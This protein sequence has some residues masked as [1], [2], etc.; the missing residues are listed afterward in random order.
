[1]QAGKNNRTPARAAAAIIA[2]ATFAVA[3]R[4]TAQEG[5][6]DTIY[7]AGTTFTQAADREWAYVIWDNTTPGP[8][9][10]Q[11]F[12][13]YAKAGNAPSPG[14]Y[15]RKSVLGVQTDPAV[16]KVLL[17]RA[18]NIGDNPNELDHRL[19]NLFQHLMPPS[20]IPVEQKLAIVIQGSLGDPDNYESLLLLAR[21]HPGV[22]M[23]LG[24]AC[25]ELIS[26]NGPTTF[27]IRQFDL[28][29]NQDIAVVGRVTVTAKSPLVLPAPGA[30]VPVPETDNKG[31]AKTHSAKGNL[32]VKLR[33]A[34]PHELRRLSIM[35]YGFNVY[36]YSR[37]A[38]EAK[39]YHATPPSV[40][41]LKADGTSGLAV[42]INE[43]PIITDNDFDPANPANPTAN[44]NDVANFNQALGGD[45]TTWFVADDNGGNR[46]GGVKFQNGD[47]FYYFVTA[48]DI[49]GR[50]GLVSPGRLVTLCDRLPPPAPEGVE[51]ENDYAFDAVSGTSSQRLKVLWRPYDGTNDTV[52]G[53]HVYR[54][55]NAADVQ[56]PAVRATNAPAS[57]LIPL[58]SGQTTQG[59]V[60]NG[61]NAPQM[62]LHSGLAFWYTVRAVDNSACGGNVSPDSAP[63]F[64]VLRDRVG[65]AAPTGRLL[66]Q[67]VRPFVEFVTA[68][69]LTWQDPDP[70][71]AAYQI[72]CTRDGLGGEEIQWAEFFWSLLGHGGAGQPVTSNYI[73][74]VFFPPAYSPGEFVNVPLLI[75]RSN[76]TSADLM[77]YCRAGAKNGK[78]SN[79][80]PFGPAPLPAPDQFLGVLFHS[81]IQT[82]RTESCDGHTP[83][84]PGTNKITGIEICANVTAGAKEY[85]IYRRVDNGPLTLIKQGK[86]EGSPV[87]HTNLDLPGSSGTI[88][89]YV[90]FLDEHGNASPVTQIGDCTPV[91]GLGKLPKPLLAEVEA[92]GTKAAPR[93]ILRWFCPPAGIDRFRV[94]IAQDF[95]EPPDVFGPDL[96]PNIFANQTPPTSEE[97][98][99][100]DGV[101]TNKTFKGYLT[102]PIGPAFGDGASFEVDV[103][104]VTVGKRYTVFVRAVDKA[105]NLSDP[106]NGEQFKWSVHKKPALE[107]PW[108]ARDLPEVSGFNSNIAAMVMHTNSF[109]GLGVRIGHHIFK[110][111][112]DYHYR[113]LPTLTDPVEYL[114]DGPKNEPLLP[115]AMYRY[116]VANVFFPQVSGDV[117]QV[118]PLMER[119]AFREVTN[120]DKPFV[121]IFD[122]FIGM[123]PE[124]G[125]IAVEL[126]FYLIGIH[127]LDTQPV[128]RGAAYRYLLVRFDP[129]T[130]EIVQVIPTN[131]VHVP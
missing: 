14:L 65:P 91:G 93:M 38:A 102:L 99:T 79:L 83:V 23:C 80:A 21:L 11:H 8:A 74:R 67:C 40:A 88:C 47:Q 20:G 50:D 130:K 125:P 2:A 43:L 17:N 13:V 86:I 44:T 10:N 24:T 34:T 71:V 39:N 48:R 129:K 54:W 105:G 33:W 9:V 122:P 59:F 1:M 3:G 51:V 78:V 95:G 92:A 66:V 117:V 15:T 131:E 114:Y 25:A 123:D 56:K 110:D 6:E 112:D 108:P 90:Q 49:L 96:S 97:Q 103:P 42:R 31:N 120:V 16:I 4:V 18:M 46:P 32:N 118:T 68:T 35:N 107:V 76:V 57:P 126:P 27:E 63:V 128:I 85:R 89:Y 94:Y 69:P 60:D 113:D 19:R 87:C 81:A 111:P 100:L 127:L 55:M 52:V 72:A 75:A 119:I 12:A 106:S 62:P 115:V 5:L 73:A 104:N 101:K 7:T 77:L 61:A 124:I 30:P 98:F 36:R 28:A 37:A 45:S 53:Y 58:A 121:R 109:K 64:G 116:Q 84:I 26:T 41:A 82:L 29:K 70:E 22:A